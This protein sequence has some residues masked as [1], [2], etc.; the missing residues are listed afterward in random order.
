MER[1]GGDVKH[2][3]LPA[4]HFQ[5]EADLWGMVDRWVQAG[6]PLDHVGSVA[7]FFVSRID[8]A[9]DALVEAKLKIANGP[10]AVRLKTIRGRVAIA[11]AKVAYQRYKKIFTGPRWEALRAKGAG[12]AVLGRQRVRQRLLRGRR[13]LH[14]SLHR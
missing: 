5:I 4:H 7:S 9:V 11:N 6:K 13:L 10:E 1:L 2:E 8:S 3:W 14:D 12:A